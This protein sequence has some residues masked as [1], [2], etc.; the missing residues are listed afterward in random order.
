MRMYIK[1]MACAFPKCRDE[2]VLVWLEKPLCQKHWDYVCE[3]PDKAR[4][5]L[6]M[7]PRLPMRVPNEQEPEREPITENG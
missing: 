1:K 2:E 6:G 4:V 3:F 7:E 5:R